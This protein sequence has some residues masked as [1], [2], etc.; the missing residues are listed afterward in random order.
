VLRENLTELQA[1]NSRHE[2][3]REGLEE[4]LEQGRREGRERGRTEGREEVLREALQAA[5]DG[6]TANSPPSSRGPGRP[7]SLEEET[8]EMLRIIG[9]NPNRDD[10][11]CRRLFE[12]ALRQREPHPKDSE[13]DYKRWLNQRSKRAWEAAQKKT[14]RRCLIRVK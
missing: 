12:A 14:V 2:G 6:A 8:G 3:R 1:A 13:S 4:G 7:S 9:D 10:R 11:Y 5:G